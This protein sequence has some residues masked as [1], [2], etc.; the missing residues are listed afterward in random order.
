MLQHCSGGGRGDSASGRSSGDFFANARIIALPKFYR[1][2]KLQPWGVRPTDYAALGFRWIFNAEP[3]SLKILILHLEQRQIENPSVQVSKQLRAL[4]FYSRWLDSWAVPLALALSKFQN[5]ALGL[6][7]RKS[8]QARESRRRALY[9]LGNDPHGHNQ[10]QGLPL[11]VHLS[12][13]TGNRDV[14]RSP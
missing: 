3:F 5:W 7:P 9:R 8:R 6:L 13:W 4:R 14:S 12:L 10:I 2:Y 1:F 11:S